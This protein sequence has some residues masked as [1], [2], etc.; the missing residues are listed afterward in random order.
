MATDRA[1]ASATAETR[2]ALVAERYPRTMAEVDALCAIADPESEPFRVGTP[3]PR[4][5]SPSR[6]P[7]RDPSPTTLSTPP[8]RTSARWWTFVRSSRAV[9]APSPSTPRTGARARPSS[10]ARER[11]S[12]APQRAHPRAARP[13]SRPTTP[14]VSSGA[15]AATPSAPF[16][17][18]HAA[19]DAY[20][21]PAA[22]GAPRGSIPEEETARTETLFF[23]AQAYARV[24]REEDSASACAACLRR[25]VERAGIN[26]LPPRI[27]RS[28]RKT[29]RN[30]P[31]FTSRRAAAAARH[32]VAAAER[33]FRDAHPTW[34]P[35]H[36]L[37]LTADERAAENV[38]GADPRA[39]A[40]PDPDDAA[41]VGANVQLAWGKLHLRRLTTARISPSPR[42]AAARRTRPRRRG[43]P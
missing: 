1:A 30:S 25:Q 2:R 19:R 37:H 40:A 21:A 17:F 3:P 23:L 8:T 28:G 24:G 27:R 39:T 22:D 34:A 15:T 20:D 13:S 41:D 42:E 10:N 11:S 12:L 26:L 35:K 16:A 5:S 29:P 33:V 14:S 7:S 38:T 9:A 43:R 36:D 18:L 31:A 4:R 32:C 6:N